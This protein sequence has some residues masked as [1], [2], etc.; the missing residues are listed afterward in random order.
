M[1]DAFEHWL[2][3]RIAAATQCPES[4]IRQHWPFVHAA[5]D[6]RGIGD[7]PVQ[8]AAIA[9]IAIETASTFEPVR[10]A[11]WLTEEW[12]RANLRYWPH[13]GR[14]YVQLTWESNYRLYGAL[15]GVDLVS[16]PDLALAPAVAADV[17]AAY[18]VTHGGGP[19]IPAAAR[20][21]N[22]REVRRLVQGG[23][24]GLDRFIAIVNALGGAMPNVT[25]DANTPAIAQDD[26]WSCAPTSLRW[27]LTAL[28]RNP[29]PAYIENLMLRDGVVTREHGLMDAT[30]AGLA[31]WIGKTGP[32][33]YGSD[34]F[35]GNHE[36]S[37]TFDWAAFEGGHPDGSNHA[38][39]VL[40]GGR[41]WG[42]WCGLRG[43]DPVRKVLLLA[44]PSPGWMGVQHTMD[45]PTFDA[46]GT[47]SAVRVLHP[48]LLEAPPPPPPPP[49]DTRLA[50]ARVLMQQAITVLD[51]PYP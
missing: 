8:L 44:N 12:R 1:G 16:E 46:L 35:Y 34:G 28:G 42:H 17:L 25:Y 3:Q 48:D 30:G 4:S 41:A 31:A 43:F 24:A 47:F 14:G 39:P 51:E 18:F 5:L 11:F 29:G 33:Y 15:L 26:P 13:Y 22:W 20:I 10:E 36:P 49:A 40:L 32:E 7:R 21:G 37:V 23:S 27:A 38:Y 19:L 45:R 50:R 9:T 6:A 2:P